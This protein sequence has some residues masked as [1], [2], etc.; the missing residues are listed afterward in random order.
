MGG[1]SAH[2]RD[3]GAASARAAGLHAQRPV[4]HADHGLELL[5]A[6]RCAHQP[7][8]RHIFG[9]AI[10]VVLA[11]PTFA[12]SS[13]TTT[14]TICPS[15]TGLLSLQQHARHER[16]WRGGRVWSRVRL[17]TCH[18]WARGCGATGGCARGRVGGGGNGEPAGVVERRAWRVWLPRCATRC[19][20][21]RQSSERLGLGSRLGLGL[22]IG[23]ENAGGWSNGI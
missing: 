7:A 18:E 15:P 6:R 10:T 13:T 5:H 14:T 9:F 12:R 2:G 21:G 23:L 20:G 17:S 4:N 16:A 3:G 22:E 8:Q 19:S 1:S 11:R